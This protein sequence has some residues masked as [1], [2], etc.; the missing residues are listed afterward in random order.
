MI[1]VPVLLTGFGAA[2]AQEKPD[3]SGEELQKKLA[4]PVADLIS[5]PFQYTGTFNVGLLDKAQHTLNIQPVYPMKLNVEW[6]LIHRAIVPLLSMP[7]LTPGQ[8]SEQ[9]M[10]I[11]RAHV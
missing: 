6:S 11:G 4:N 5:V 10:E 9:G 3:E 2:F 8:G 1:A 7:E